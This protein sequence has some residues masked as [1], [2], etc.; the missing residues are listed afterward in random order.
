MLHWWFSNY[1]LQNVGEDQEA[2]SKK[3]IGSSTPTS[4]SLL[5]SLKI[6]YYFELKN[7]L[8]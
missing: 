3:D 4:I 2:L 5:L 6:Q 7:L 1:A 8:L